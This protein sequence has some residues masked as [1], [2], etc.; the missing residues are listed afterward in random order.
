VFQSRGA[1]SLPQPHPGASNPSSGATSAS[2]PDQEPQPQMS[3][4]SS[5]SQTPVP[6]EEPSSRV[7]QDLLAERSARL[8]VHKKEQ[9]AKEKAKRA[10]EAKARK[11]AL[12]EATPPDSKKSADMKYALMQKKRQQD[13][14][15]ERARILK[16]VE[17]DK[18]ERRER[19]AQR[20]ALAKELETTQNEGSTA[21]SSGITPSSLSRSKECALQVRLFD[22]STVRSRFSSQGTLRGDVRPW[23][24]GQQAGDIP[25]TF[26]HVLTPLPNKNISISDEEQTLQ[27]QG[28][29][30]SATLI[31]V[32]VQDYTSAYSDSGAMSLVTRGVSAGW[33]AVSS[34][35]SLVTGTLGGILGWGGTGAQV[36]AT[37]SAPVSTALPSSVNVRTLRDQDR[38]EDHQFY[39][40]NAVSHVSAIFEST[41]L[42]NICVA[43][44]RA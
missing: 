20:K 1:T 11:A 42:I 38:P 40:G 28:L 17:D 44:F 22:G 34:G 13:A 43:Q 12:E 29:T 39:N 3:S 14:R 31:L 24:D 33:V 5:S 25:Y 8:E 41:S 9:E 32:P 10:A 16:R 6:A 23:I 35:A 15:E 2:V 4:S 27:S 18:A 36:P 19:E 7:V 26:K 37:E 21:A 30:P